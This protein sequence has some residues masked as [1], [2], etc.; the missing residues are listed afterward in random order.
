MYRYKTFD[1]ESFKE[2]TKAEQKAV[3][4]EAERV[5]YNTDLRSY[6]GCSQFNIVPNQL[7]LL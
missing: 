6:F 7:S 3:N 4:I 5:K 1:D 2:I